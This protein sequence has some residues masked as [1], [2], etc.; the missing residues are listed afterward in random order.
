MRHS[1]ARRSFL[2][3]MG[4][5]VRLT[6]RSGSHERQQP[7]IAFP[8]RWSGRRMWRLAMAVGM[9]GAGFCLVLA[10][11]VLV[12]A[13]GGGASTRPPPGSTRTSPGVLPRSGHHRYQTT[14]VYEPRPVAGN[15]SASAVRYGLGLLV[16]QFRG[17]GSVQGDRFRITR[18]GDWGISWQFRCTQ[19][20]P[21]KLTVNADGTTGSGQGQG[22][23]HQL[24]NGHGHGH[25]NGNGGQPPG[26]AKKHKHKVPPGQAKKNK[27]KASKKAVKA[28]KHGN[29]NQAHGTNQ[30]SG[31]QNSRVTLIASG[32]GG[33]GMSWYTSDPGDHTLEVTSGCTWAIK[34][35]LP[36]P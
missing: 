15:G 13:L 7:A 3:R 32:Y 6:D 28:K 35:V 18:P 14:I 11:V 17:T 5:H 8:A 34:I 29:G 21:G 16:A 27:H 4:D 24:N 25:G 10:M 26:Q 1:P 23:G 19:G 12:V 31:N 9:A 20:H 30:A 36:K 22:Y 33:R 2:A